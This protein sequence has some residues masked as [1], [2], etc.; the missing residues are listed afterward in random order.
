M[1]IL[2]CCQMC[3]DSCDLTLRA[4]TIWFGGQGSI[5]FC[6][7]PMW[8]DQVLSSNISIWKLRGLGLVFHTTAYHEDEKM[9][10]NSFWLDGEWGRRQLKLFLLGGRGGQRQLKKKKPFKNIHCSCFYTASYNWI[11]WLTYPLNSDMY[12]NGF[13]VIIVPFH[14]YIP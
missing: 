9:I 13:L 3:F 4:S 2:Y 6:L 12:C 7:W 11:L 1:S 8:L 5:D 14:K 10:S